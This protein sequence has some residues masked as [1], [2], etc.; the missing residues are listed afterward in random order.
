M[1]E[2]TASFKGGEVKVLNNFSEFWKKVLLSQ[3]I[4][5]FSPFPNPE[6]FNLKKRIKVIVGT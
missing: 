4:N 1:V 2:P 6:F 3:L 5:Q